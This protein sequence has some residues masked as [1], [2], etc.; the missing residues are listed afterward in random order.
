MVIC[1]CV[2]WAL[3]P[4]IKLIWFEL[5][6]FLHAGYSVYFC[7]VLFYRCILTVF[8]LKR[9][10]N[11]WMN[12]IDGWMAMNE[13]TNEWYFIGWPQKVM[14]LFVTVCITSLKRTNFRDFCL[15][16]ISKNGFF[17]YPFTSLFSVVLKTWP[18]KQVISLFWITLYNGA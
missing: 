11:E 14:P 8:L 4:E 3:S 13:C 17:I 10:M 15:L 16:K 12:G 6:N 18:V 7:F 1:V 5:H 2:L 9:W